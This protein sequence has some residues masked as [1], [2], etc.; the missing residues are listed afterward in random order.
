MMKGMLKAAVALAIGMLATLTGCVFV[1]LHH[2]PA[3]MSNEKLVALLLAPIV[4]G[5]V[6]G[7]VVYRILER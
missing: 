5:V 3:V 1:D 7:V 6:V 2:W 4:I